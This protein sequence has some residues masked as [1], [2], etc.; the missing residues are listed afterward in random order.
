MEK[1]KHES[2]LTSEQQDFQ[3]KIKQKFRDHRG[4]WSEGIWS[5]MLHLHPHFLG[6]YLDF[7]L[8]PFEKNYLS[9]KE[10]EL[11][12]IAFDVSAT[13][14][15]APGTEAHMV[16]A[17]E[18]G[19]TKEEILEVIEI[20]S[21]LGMQTLHMGAPILIDELKAR[22]EKVDTDF[23]KE[24]EAL[25][26]QFIEQHGYWDEIWEAPLLL[27]P[28]L[29]AAYL[30]LSEKPA[31]KGQLTP[32]MRQFAFIA[33]DAAGTHLNKQGM[34]MHIR[35]ALAAGAVKEEIT[36]V[37]ELVSTMGIHAATTSVPILEK[38][39]KQQG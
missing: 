21:L 29:F 35:N 26:Q 37:F 8:V 9:L 32:K 4:Y 15:Y 7:S 17:L 10:K 33:V 25:K 14:M 28:S 1:N 19:A 30:G 23:T 22:G 11:I 36:E 31:G 16:N 38:V 13:H 5:S 39:L 24:Q 27:S 2:S 12:Y 18:Y 3:E 20:A 34:Q 6:K